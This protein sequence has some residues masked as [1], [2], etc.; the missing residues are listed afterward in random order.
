MKYKVIVICKF[1]FCD[2]MRRIVSIEAIFGDRVNPLK[3]DYPFYNLVPSS[4]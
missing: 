2:A 1:L 3:K 4:D